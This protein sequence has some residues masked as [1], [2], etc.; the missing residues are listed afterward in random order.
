M[1]KELELE[2]EH[3]TMGR[4]NPGSWGKYQTGRKLFGRGIRINE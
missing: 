3:D 1:E 4:N 2:L